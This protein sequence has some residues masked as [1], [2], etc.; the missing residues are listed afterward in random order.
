MGFGLY[1]GDRGALAVSEGWDRME[2]GFYVRTTLLCVCVARVCG[3]QD[4]SRS[5]DRPG[6]APGSSSGVRDAVW[7]WGAVFAQTLRAPQRRLCLGQWE[8]VMEAG[9]VPGRPLE[10][11]E[12]A[13]PFSLLMSPL[14]PQPQ[15]AEGPRASRGPVQYG[16]VWE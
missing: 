11:Y 9:G 16:T 13:E 3:S 4:R 10:Q 2:F 15:R 6:K 7:G 5:P 8:V 12:W 1:V 14:W